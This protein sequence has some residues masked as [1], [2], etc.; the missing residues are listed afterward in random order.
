MSEVPSH[1]TS[2]IIP[3]YNEADRLSPFLATIVDFVKREPDQIQEIIIVDDGS[4][5][6]TL[7]VAESWRGK[8]GGLKILRHPENR[9]KGAAIQ[10]GVRA[11]RG[12]LIVFIDA[13]GATPID[14]LPKLSAALHHADMAVGNRWMP[15]AQTARTSAVRKFSGLIYRSYMRLFGLGAVDTMCG[16]KG[17]RADIAQ[18]LFNTLLAPRWLFDTEI[19]YRAHLRR[20]RVVNVPIHWTSKDG[21]K[22]STLTL[23]RSAWQILPLVHAVRKFERNKSQ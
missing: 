8:L 1:T 21:S 4:T 7:A 13:D 17:Y 22:L 19:A 16:F 15:G 10:T 9:G 3:A 5:D 18:S 12:S 14:E 23:L 20:H 2:L 11:A 6:K